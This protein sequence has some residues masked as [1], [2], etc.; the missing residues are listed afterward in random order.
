M[1]KDAIQLNIAQNNCHEQEQKLNDDYA[2]KFVKSIMHKFCNNW[3][4]LEVQ[5]II[6]VNNLL[7]EIKT[8][9]NDEKICNS[10][11]RMRLWQNF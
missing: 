1:I 4:W 3:Q 10:N 7:V 5:R 8:I 11:I 2:S 6:E 9:S